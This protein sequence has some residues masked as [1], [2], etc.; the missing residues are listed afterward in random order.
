MNKD[1]VLIVYFSGT[2]STKRIAETFEEIFNERH[3]YT[4]KYP[5]DLSIKKSL[6][7]QYNEIIHKVKLLLVIYPVYAFD[8]PQPVYDWIEDLTFE[9]DIPTVVISV[10]GG[11]NIWP[12]T[13]CRVSCIKALEKK[14]YKVFY[15]KML[16]MPSNFVV[17][18]N[19]DLSMWLL[20]KIPVVTNKIAN[21]VIIG[22]RHRTGFKIG[23]K[24]IHLFSRIEKKYSG[25]FGLSLMTKESCNGCGW[26]A[27]NCPSNNISM[28]E[29]KPIFSNQCI[30]CMRCIY[31]CPLKAIYTDKYKFIIIKD[32]YSIESI[33]ERMKE[34]ELQPVKKCS[35]GYLW[36]GVRKYLLEKD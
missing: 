4:I 7:T 3:Y 26:C 19:D 11:G 8:A 35:K 9:N 28:V 22:K 25:L 2:G 15:E 16:V 5:L 18:T 20:K 32:G 17:K 24:F 12:N 30:V 6:S 1:N 21:D 10:S 14:G 27:K 34:K 31:G 13:L 29:E 36:S 33:E 23:T